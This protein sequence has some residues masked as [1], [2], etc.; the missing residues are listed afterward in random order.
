MLF[1][2]LIFPFTV[3]LTPPAGFPSDTHLGSR[4]SPAGAFNLEIIEII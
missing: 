3:H 4:R 2:I 1:G